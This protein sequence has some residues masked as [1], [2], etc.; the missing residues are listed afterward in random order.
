[1]SDFY[2]YD[3]ICIGSGPAGQR[4]AVQA[5]KIGKRAAVVDRCRVLGGVC[6]DTGTI[7]SKTFREA[8]RSFIRPFQL[9]GHPSRPRLK[10]RPAMPQLLARVNEVVQLEADIV[11]DQLQRNDIAI[12]RGT[13]MFEDPH[14]IAVHA[15]GEL[16]RL[17]GRHILIACGTKP[18][19]PPGVQLDGEVII[20]SDEILQLK[21]LPR[22][23][24]VVGGGVIGIEYASMFAALGVEVTVV[25]GRKR[26]LEFLDHEIVDELIHQM[27]NMNV[28][29][30]LGEA[31]EKLD[32]TG[33]PDRKAVVF[34][35]SGKRLV[36]DVVL[37]SVG[38]VGATGFLNLPAAGLTP[39]NRGR[40]EVDKDFRTRV[41]HI[42][43]AGDV[44]GHPSLAATSYAQ[45][46]YVANVAFGRPATPLP[47]HL[48][49]GIYAIPELSMI[50]HT[51]Q[52]LT[53]R[54]VPYEVGIA[55]F[56]EIARG[57]MLGDDSGFFK[58]LFNRDERRL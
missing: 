12:F 31:V 3:L 56:R 39:D 55:R 38:R 10:D 46:R 58:M 2:D 32:V 9:R 54:K 17:T 28:Q 4:A 11:E 53:E 5:A 7:P 33:G 21:R 19:P 8:V 18:A 15:G 22:K 29:F 1:M 44:I 47:K 25:D 24:A 42:F 23:L 57:Q 20:T 30:R 51:E 41:A 34:L 35:E 45:G 16:R 48:P 37:F 26:P 27:R 40:L 13:G 14:T 52:E 36:S 50:G 6:V 49:I 43:A